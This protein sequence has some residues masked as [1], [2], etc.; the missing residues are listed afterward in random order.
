MIETPSGIIVP[1][2][3]EK[4]MSVDKAAIGAAVALYEVDQPLWQARTSPQ[5]FFKQAQGLYHSNPWIHLAERTVAGRIAS[6][7]YHIE[8]EQG[9]ELK[10]P[11]EPTLAA[12]VKLLERPNARMTRREMW[13][14]TARHMGLC[15][16]A[17]WYLD[18]IDALL[19]VPE[20]IYYLNP[21]RLTPAENKAGELIGWVLDA[22]SYDGSSGMPLTL[23]EVISFPLD[24]PD[25]GHYGIGLV[26]SAGMKATITTLV[27]RHTSGVYG[28]GGRLAGIVAP[29]DGTL[30]QD[31]FDS[32]VRE[33][34]AVVERPD[35]AKRLT[36]V[37]GPIDFTPTAANPQELS[38][39]DTSQANRD[40]I[41]AM[42]GVPLSQAGI[43]TP[44]G[45]GG[46]EGRRFD[47]AA[48][49]QNAIAP[50][51]SGFLEKLQFEWIDRYQ[52][53]WQLIIEEP[54]F[55]DEAPR[56]DLA[57]KAVNI[58]L[59]NAQRLELV[60]QPPTG[61]PA[62]D[63]AVYLPATLVP[64]GT[65]PVGKATLAT[66]VPPNPRQHPALRVARRVAFERFL[67]RLRKSIGE[68]LAEQRRTIAARLREHAAH[69]QANPA[70]S[71]VWWSPKDAATWQ[72]K[73]RTAIRAHYAAI[74]DTVGR[75]VPAALPQKA[76]P[77][78]EAF[79]DRILARILTLGGERVTDINETTRADVQ[80][81]V[82]E[83]IATG[84]T[85][86]Q[87]ADNLE[88]FAGF[89]EYRSELIARTETMFAYNAGAIGGYQDLGIREV[90]A[91]DG[92]KDEE[93]AA[94]DG[95]T[96]PVEEAYSIIDHP[97]GTLDWIPLV[98][99]GKAVSAQS[100]GPAEP[101]LDAM[102]EARAKR[103]STLDDQH[104]ELMAA[105]A[106]DREE[107]KAAL[108]RR[109]ADTTRAIEDREAHFGAL[110]EAG[111]RELTARQ[112]AF[113]ARIE[114]PRKRTIQR[115]EG[116]RIIGLVE[117]TA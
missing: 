97:N 89:S 72:E 32:L 70:D 53:G 106:R 49:W 75:A 38:L 98:G 69:V 83:G 116:G 114:A 74:A 19:G 104:E 82:A 5:A 108:A 110:L 95:R 16:V 3:P 71:A 47:E 107:A 62:I 76:E 60:G 105:V 113:A 6:L 13:Q 1:R 59:T 67:P 63:N 94:R 39:V 52:R 4:A 96:F 117:E 78:D 48:M 30:G 21:A 79:I 12:F 17:F 42:W 112:D 20:A 101:L 23:D 28:S 40:D 31:A 9:N 11:Y 80:R 77:W 84:L 41:L 26:E 35:A 99:A 46:S 54:S 51:L 34:R 90:E 100:F 73:L 15:G 24:P 18:R 109:D 115:D 37:K 88:D 8:D 36:V 102:L 14:I 58:P 45:L 93:C 27:D 55:D 2:L 22:K 61:D 10:A 103:K 7:A 91:S 81:F 56:Y 43:P 64:I 66:E 65:V 87:I 29:K 92:D 111:L 86:S 25:Q 68:L 33:F 50:R 85:P 57:A 44:Q